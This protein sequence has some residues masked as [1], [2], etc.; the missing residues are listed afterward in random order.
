MEKAYHA[1]TKH[2]KGGMA[3]LILRQSF[4]KNKERRRDIS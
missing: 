4:T 3:V 1:S 2:K